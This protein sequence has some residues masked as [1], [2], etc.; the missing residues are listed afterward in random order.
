MDLGIAGRKA[1][2]C[3]SSRGLGKACAEALAAEG[4]HVIINGVTPERVAEVAEEIRKKGGNAT[5]VVADIVTDEGRAKLLA[6]CPEP[7]IL[8]NNNAGPD[9][10]PF[11]EIDGEAWRKGLESGMISPLLL[12][13][14]V[15]PGMRQRKFGRIINITS[16]MVRMPNPAMGLS[17]GPRIG[18]T[19]VSKAVSRDTARDNVTINNIL[20][21]LFDTDRQVQMARL[22]MQREKISWE[23]ARKRQVENTITKR[24]GDPREF[25]ATCA[26]LCSNYGSYI[27]GQNILLDGGNFPGVF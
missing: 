8:V 25:G 18:L 5:P 6:S 17:A 3:A 12:I 24:L 2:C 19:G 27:C 7:D 1:I 4:V 21:Y 23:D 11:V 26:F 14:A 20:P 22:M 10:K 9:P 13:R 15:L 16:E